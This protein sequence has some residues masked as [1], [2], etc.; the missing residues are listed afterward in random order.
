[1]PDLFVARDTSAYSAYYTRLQSH[2]LVREFALNFYQDHKTELEAMRFEQFNSTFRISDAQLQALTAKAAH[3]GVP[4]DAAGMRRCSTL[5]KD[6]LKALIARSAY[7]KTAYYQV[8]RDQ[9]AELQ[10]ALRA[11]GDDGS[12]LLGLLK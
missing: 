3:D 1:M 4:A 10:Q 9:D 7:G 6:Q 5:L 2:N 12:T 8:L 11:L